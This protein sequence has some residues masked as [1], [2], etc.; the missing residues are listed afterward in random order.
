[1]PMSVFGASAAIDGSWV[2]IEPSLKVYLQIIHLTIWYLCAQWPQFVTGLDKTL[3]VSTRI[4]I[5][6]GDLILCRSL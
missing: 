3:C 6:A 5:T 4:K 2:S 1:M